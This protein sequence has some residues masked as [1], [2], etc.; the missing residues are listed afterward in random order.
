[1]SKKNYLFKRVLNFQFVNVNKYVSLAA[2]LFFV[3]AVNCKK[4]SDS[5]SEDD[6][7]LPDLT[8]I[9]ANKADKANVFDFY[10]FQSNVNISAFEGDE[11]L[12]GSFHFTGS[13]SN[14]QIQFT[15]DGGSS[16]SGKSY[17]GTI[18]ESSNVITLTSADFG[19][20]ILEKQP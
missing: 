5:N 15:Y 16:K 19:N 9:W 4:E 8:K 18:N 10:N 3:I 12:L 11:H 6:F 20:L 7:F 17:S 2:L 13:F 1:M 14:H